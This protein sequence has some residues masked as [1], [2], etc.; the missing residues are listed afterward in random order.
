MSSR[1]PFSNQRRLW[2]DWLVLACALIVVAFTF[3]RF[4]Q[5]ETA[6]KLVIRQG[7]RV[8][9]SYSLDQDRT[10]D[11]HGPLGNSRVE[12]AHG[13]VR[14]SSAPCTNQ[15]CVHH[16]WLS[17]VGQVAICL[18][19]QVSLELIGAKRPYDSLNY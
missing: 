2:G 5:N 19:N 1:N 4:W 16:G 10:L 9:A 15:Y 18:P 17:K 8:F 12:I 14:F 7:D 6:G 13:K 11:I 3:Y